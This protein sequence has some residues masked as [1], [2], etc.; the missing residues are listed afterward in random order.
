M[1]RRFQGLG[2]DNVI[3]LDH[4]QSCPLAADFVA[5]MYLDT[6]HKEDSGLLLDMS[7]FRFLDL[8]DCNTPMSE[9]PKEVDVL[10]AQFSGAMWVS[11]LLRLLA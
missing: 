8:N 6:S 4:Q 9:L 5:T 2:F 3:A 10:A 7:G 1:M 11:W